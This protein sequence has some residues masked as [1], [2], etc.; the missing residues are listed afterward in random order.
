MVGHY[1]TGFIDTRRKTL[2]YGA[3]IAYVCLVIALFLLGGL[4]FAHAPSHQKPHDAPL[5]AG[6]TCAM[7]ACNDGGN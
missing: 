7:R 1:T 6:L 4:I 2:L 3:L 5:K